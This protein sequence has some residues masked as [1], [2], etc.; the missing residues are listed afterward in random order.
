MPGAAEFLHTG[1]KFMDCP[2]AATFHSCHIDLVGGEEPGSGIFKF[3]ITPALTELQDGS[4]RA[5][6]ASV[7]GDA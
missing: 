4:A 1:G 3:G 6:R 5:E 7:H 2:L